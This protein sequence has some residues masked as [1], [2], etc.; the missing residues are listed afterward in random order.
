M[1]RNWLCTDLDK[2]IACQ[3]FLAVH[4][5]ESWSTEL[6]EVWWLQLEDIP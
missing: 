2:P 5:G 4:Q 1:T 3:Y 6:L